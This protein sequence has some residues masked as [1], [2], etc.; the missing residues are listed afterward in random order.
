MTTLKNKVIKFGE[1]DSSNNEDFNHPGQSVTQHCKSYVFDLHQTNERKL[2]IVDT[3]GFGDTRGLD[4]DDQNMEHI[5]QYI[6]NLTHLNAICFLLKPNSSRLNMFF[7]TCFTQLFSFLNP[8]ARQNVIFCFTGSRSTFYTPGDTA[9][10][11]KTM[12]NSLSITDIP[13]GKGNTFCFD[14]ESFRYLV[15][16]QNEVSFSDDD[17]REYERSW[18]NSVKESNRLINHIAT[19]LTSYDMKSGWQSVK[20]AQFEISHMI[21]PMSE[22]MRNVLRNIIL[23]KNNLPNESIVLHSKPLHRT[24]TRCRNCKPHP[25]QVGKFWVLPTVPHEIQDGCFMCSCALDQHV[26]VDYMLEYDLLNNSSKL[27]LN[28]MIAVINS[29]CDAGTDFAHFLIHTAGSKKGD[30]FFI[31]LV[32][33]IVEETS[34]CKSKETAH[35]NTQLVEEL[36]KLQN[37]YEQHMDKKKSNRKNV[38]L[39]AIYK[40]IEIIGN[41]SMVREQM[42]AMKQTQRI[43]MEEYEYEVEAI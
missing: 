34:I 21:R 10:L 6:N 42:V 31:G 9:P 43:V 1:V 22:T 11:L 26:S 25:Y 30:P 14:S 40:L 16:I 13:F 8:D 12:L 15:A 20:N 3:P 7:R 39:S 2:R 18:S 38:E 23:C 28:Q 24:A 35:L 32:E 33:M 27:S 36:R 41:H 19:N 17:K 37:R 29:L 4:Q 5:L